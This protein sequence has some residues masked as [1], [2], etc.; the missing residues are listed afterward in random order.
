M[1]SRASSL[2]EPQQPCTLV[3]LR[4]PVR[5]C[6]GWQARVRGGADALACRIQLQGVVA[7][8]C[9]AHGGNC[10]VWNSVLVSADHSFHGLDHGSCPAGGTGSEAGWWPAPGGPGSERQ[11]LSS[12]AP[13]PVAGCAASYVPHGAVL[14][15]AAWSSRVQLQYSRRSA[16]M[17]AWPAPVCLAS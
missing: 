2:S 5:C 13:R 12:P 8:A 10:Q 9:G 4:A 14:V 11:A 3:V 7:G 15:G 6:A 1:L 16:L 17:Q